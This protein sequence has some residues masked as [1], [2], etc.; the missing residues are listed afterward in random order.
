MF[1]PLTI[2]QSVGGVKDFV[3]GKIIVG[4]SHVEQRVNEW[5]DGLR[6]SSRCAN[7]SV[8]IGGLPDCPEVG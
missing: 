4:R 1:S 5:T 3:V 8:R 6:C 7:R 2:G